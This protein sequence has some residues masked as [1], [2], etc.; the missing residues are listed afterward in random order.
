MV[1]ILAGSRHSEDASDS[2]VAV[3]VAVFD[4]SGDV[5]SQRCYMSSQVLSS[6]IP[7]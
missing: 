2:V 1:F 7:E 3:A 6:W 4:G 5:D